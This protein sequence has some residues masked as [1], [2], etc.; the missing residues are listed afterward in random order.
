MNYYTFFDADSIP[1]PKTRKLFKEV[2]SSYVIENYRAAIVMLYSVTICDLIYKLID[3]RDIYGDETAADILSGASSFSDETTRKNWERTLI[4]KIHKRTD[5]LSQE[6]CDAIERLH[7]VRNYAAH[8]TFSTSFELS[9]P[10]KE[11]VIAHMKEMLHHILTRPCYFGKSEIDPM[12]E[13]LDRFRDSFDQGY[14]QW[15]RFLDRR[16]YSH[17]LPERIAPW[18]SSL[19]SLCFNKPDNE[20]CSRNRKQLVFALR[21]LLDSR[22]QECISVLTNDTDRYVIDPSDATVFSAIDVLTFHSDL[23]QFVNEEAKSV[24]RTSSRKDINMSA[25]AFFLSPSLSEHMAM[26]DRHMEMHRSGQSPIV[27]TVAER[28]F[29][30]AS[31]NGEKDSILDHYISWYAGS[32]QFDAADERFD[33]FIAPF[34]SQMEKRHFE[35]LLSETNKN[36]QIHGRRNSYRANTEIMKYAKDR[37]ECSDIGERYPNFEYNESVLGEQST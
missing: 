18:F 8:P 12:L 17:V 33:I 2:L 5:L 14:E 28:L 1:N 13:D 26:L 16:Y 10:S 20:M 21:A 25:L 15:K 27:A 3:L 19:W 35:T 32:R 24:I 6:S 22:K 30:V 4:E 9:V 36:Y 31:D 11:A 29:S 34:L 37:I 7:Q 23:Y